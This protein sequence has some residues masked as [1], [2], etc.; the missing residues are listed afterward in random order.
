MADLILNNQLRVAVHI[1]VC[2]TIHM[3]L[4]K[5]QQQNHA[6]PFYHF[7]SNLKQSLS[8]PFLGAWM[9]HIAGHHLTNPTMCC[10]VR[11]RM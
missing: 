2:N 4:D 8:A 1:F 7:S 9:W 11:G 10:H 6:E 3:S 5:C